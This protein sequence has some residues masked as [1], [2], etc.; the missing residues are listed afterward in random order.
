MLYMFFLIPTE[1][2]WYLL[3]S[4]IPVPRMNIALNDELRLSEVKYILQKY[5]LPGL[6]SERSTF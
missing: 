3:T 2:S 6:L 1:W 4:S 5:D